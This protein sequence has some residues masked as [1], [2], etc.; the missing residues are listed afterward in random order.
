MIAIEV[1]NRS[2]E[3]V[4]AVQTRQGDQG[5]FFGQQGYL[6][7]AQTR[8]QRCHS[9]LSKQGERPGKGFP[10]L[11]LLVIEEHQYVCEGLVSAERYEHL[12]GP[13]AYLTLLGS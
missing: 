7:R 1:E 4:D 3:V 13:G 6:G 12:Q 5:A 9:A 11:G 2:G 8:E 10:Y